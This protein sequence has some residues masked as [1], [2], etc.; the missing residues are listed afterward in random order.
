MGLSLTELL[1]EYLRS[2]L[3]L[4][5]KAPRFSWQLSSDKKDTL[6]TAVEIRVREAK[7]EEEVWDSGLLSTDVSTGITYEGKA[8]KPCTAYVVQVEVT[9][10]YGRKAVAETVF[11]TGFLKKDKSVW[12]GADWI[13]APDFHVAANARGVFVLES[14]FRMKEGSKRAGVVFG[15]NDFRLLDHN[16]NEYGLEGENYIRYEINRA[17]ETPVLDIYRVGYAKDDKKDVP[18]ATVELDKNVN[19]DEFHC[20]KIVVDGDKAFTYL[21]EKPVDVPETAM[22]PMK[23]SGRVL[24]PRGHNDVLTYPRLNEI[25]FFAGF[26]SFI[27]SSIRLMF[28]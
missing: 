24:N 5:E 27:I 8:L 9:D 7:T 11:E 19:F 13:G 26:F 3:G 10:N 2:P 15:A 25:G 28:W 20:L 21:D 22:G 14:T 17:G 1:V 12:E 23:I 16:Q 4:D 6:Q 18:F